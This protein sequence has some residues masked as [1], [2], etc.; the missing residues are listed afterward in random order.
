VPFEQLPAK[1][2]PPA[3]HAAGLL[4]VA[5]EP[6]DPATRGHAGSARSRAAAVTDIEEHLADEDLSP[7]MTTRR[8]GVSVRTVHTWFAGSEHSYAGTVRR[9]RL[10]RARRA[11]AD[12][13]LAHL[14]V[15]DIA[16]DAGFGNVAAFHRS[17]RRAFGRTPGDIRPD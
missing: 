14:R 9:A 1:L 11:L 17:F 5:L 4:A 3:T 10:E 13:A 6:A 8:L 12:P 16:A 2:W 7:A 15:I